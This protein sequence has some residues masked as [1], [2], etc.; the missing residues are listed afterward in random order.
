MKI[1]L[2]VCKEECPNWMHCGLITS[3]CVTLL[4]G[5]I[6]EQNSGECRDTS[7]I[8]H[9][10]AK[11]F[12][13]N[14]IV[15]CQIHQGFFT[16]KVFSIQLAV[17]SLKHMQAYETNGL[18]V[19]ISQLMVLLAKLSDPLLNNQSFCIQLLLCLLYNAESTMIIKS[20][21]LLI[22]RNYF[23]AEK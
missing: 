1:L 22:S 19:L 17:F 4:S 13:V 2:I 23:R 9:K 16:T 7:P 11:I 18:I 8:I 10:L 3:I 12:L 5:S 15:I 6:G 21:H 20:L 14:C